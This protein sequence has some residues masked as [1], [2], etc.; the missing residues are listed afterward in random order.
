[1]TLGKQVFD[2]RE[3]AIDDVTDVD[4][5]KV[6]EMNT[7][8]PG[9]SQLTIEMMDKDDIGSDDLIGKTVIDLE[10]RWF[11]KR[12]QDSGRLNRK[13]PDED[14]NNIRWD[15]KELESRTLYVPSSNNGQGVLQCWLDILTP[16]EANAFPPDDV[17]LPPRQVFE[18]RVVIWKTKDVPAQ[19]TFGG[20]VTC[21]STSSICSIY[22]TLTS[23]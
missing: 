3:N 10:D 16:G 7:E 14:P 4:L 1:V 20:Q 12:W 23:I 5:Y 13:M 22:G 17:A 21:Y 2:D 11:D 9:I 18:M 19:D 15:T 8:L 6:I